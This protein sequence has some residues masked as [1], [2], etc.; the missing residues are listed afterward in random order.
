MTKL[1]KTLIVSTLLL[2][3]SA[4]TLALEAAQGRPILTINGLIAEKNAGAEAQFDSRMID[5]LPQV[6]MT[7]PTPWYKT[8]QTFEGP[9]FRD[10][11]KAVGA[12]GKK[13]YVVALNDYAAEIPLSDLSKYDVIL[14]RK[15]NGKVLSV[16]DKG[17]LFVMYPFTKNPELQ[18]KDI[19]S[20]CVWQVNRI[21]VE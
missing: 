2:A 1:L 20:R 12:N 15:V 3:A 6:K 9:L 18:T 7:V 17:P 21:R 8:A 16:R 10:V 5:A 14:A 19:Y 11:L 4:P 13:L